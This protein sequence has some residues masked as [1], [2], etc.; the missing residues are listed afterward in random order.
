MAYEIKVGQNIFQ[1]DRVDDMWAVELDKFEIV[2]QELT[3]EQAREFYQVE[4]RVNGEQ[5]WAYYDNGW[6]C[7]FDA[8]DVEDWREV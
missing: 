5:M 6:K 4:V 7:Q 2:D 8:D 3:E 1:A